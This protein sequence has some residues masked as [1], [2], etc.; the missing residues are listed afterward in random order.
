MQA[1]EAGGALDDAGEMALAHARHTSDQGRLL[2]R[3]RLLAQRLGLVDE[4]ARLR[5]GLWVAGGLLGLLAFLLAGGLLTRALGTGQSVNAA[6]AF[7]AML[8]VP[9]V[10]LLV[11]VL[12]VAWALASAPRRAAA[13]RSATRCRA[14]ALSRPRRRGR[15]HWSTGPRPC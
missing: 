11:W 9:V 7:V 4:W 2:E 10:A 13:R 1:I 6:F 3:A 8:G 12:W 5:T 15:L 14:G